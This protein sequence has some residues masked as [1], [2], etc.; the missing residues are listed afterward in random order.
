MLGKIWSGFIA[1]CGSIIP[2]WEGPVGYPVHWLATR[3]LVYCA[4]ATLSGVLFVSGAGVYSTLASRIQTSISP[5]APTTNSEKTS[6]RPNTN[7]DASAEPNKKEGASEGLQSTTERIGAQ[8]VQIVRDGNNLRVTIQFANTYYSPL[9]VVAGV[10]DTIVYQDRVQ[11]PLVG[12]DGILSCEL[13]NTCRSS[14]AKIGVA[15]LVA[16]RTS[17]D[18]TLVAQGHNLP[19]V[20]SRVN[21]KIWIASQLLE[22]G[23]QASNSGTRWVSTLY[24]E[25]GVPV[26]AA[27][28]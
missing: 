27:R 18:V 8:F 28:P 24:Y 9:R 4:I 20:G 1:G 23:G 16:P 12:A 19:E 15:T 3:L 13:Q 17:Y 2:S 22:S 6:R 10:E 11:W 21:L 26:V 5:P 25:Y 14:D 7:T